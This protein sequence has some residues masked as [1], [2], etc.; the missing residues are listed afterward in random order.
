MLG[1]TRMVITRPCLR[2]S[3][4]DITMPSAAERRTERLR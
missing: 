4:G 3:S 1:E 2:R